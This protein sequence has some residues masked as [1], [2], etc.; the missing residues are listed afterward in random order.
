MPSA[1]TNGSLQAGRWIN[2]GRHFNWIDLARLDPIVGLNCT[3]CAYRVGTEHSADGTSAVGPKLREV[4]LAHG[5]SRIVVLLRE[6]R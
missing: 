3:K 1:S 4:A 2:L 6:R 5:R